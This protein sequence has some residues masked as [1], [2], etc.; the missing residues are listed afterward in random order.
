MIIAIYFL[1]TFYGAFHITD[2]ILYKPFQIRLCGDFCS[3]RYQVY[4]SGHCCKDQIP[5]ESLIHH[6]YE[7][8]VEDAC[9][10][11]DK[12]Y[13]ALCFFCFS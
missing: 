9:S 7:I 11:E 3:F 13:I 5:V 2:L 4:S 1:K 6:E 8:D 12:V 10:E